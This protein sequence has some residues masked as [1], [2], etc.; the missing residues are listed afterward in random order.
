MDFPYGGMRKENRI[1]KRLSKQDE[2]EHA[3][4]SW[5]QEKVIDDTKNKKQNTVLYFLYTGTVYTGKFFLWRI[6]TVYFLN[7]SAL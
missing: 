3:T 6:L 1:R 2:K 5:E 4:Q 7:N